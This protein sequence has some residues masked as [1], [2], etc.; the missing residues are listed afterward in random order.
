MKVAAPSAE[1]LKVLMNPK[2]GTKIK[3]ISHLELALVATVLDFTSD[4]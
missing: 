3:V 2:S 1:S 4:D